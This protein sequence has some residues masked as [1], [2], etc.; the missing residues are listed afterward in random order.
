MRRKLIYAVNTN[1]Q[2]TPDMVESLVDYALNTFP[3]EILDHPT[4]P[5]GAIYAWATVNNVNLSEYETTKPK[6]LPG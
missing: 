2:F 4:Y 1:W 3:I 6:S 5:N